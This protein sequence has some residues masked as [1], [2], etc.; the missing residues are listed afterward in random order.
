MLHG[1]Q[2][3]VLAPATQAW[4]GEARKL[5]N[6]NVKPSVVTFNKP[7]KGETWKKK[8]TSAERQKQLAKSARQ[9]H[10][11]ATNNKDLKKKIILT[12]IQKDIIIGTILGDSSLER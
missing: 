3:P 7:F 8:N 5:I 6:I 12:D 2:A 4:R 11:I 10:T 9:F 1:L